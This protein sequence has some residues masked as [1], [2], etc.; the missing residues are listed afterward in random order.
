MRERKDREVCVLLPNKQRL[1]FAVGVKARGREVLNR[2]LEQLGLRELHLFGLAILRDNEYLFLDLEQKLRKSFGSEWRRRSETGPFI[3]FLRVQYYVESGQLILSSKVRQL[4][5]TE[6]R[7]KVLCSQCRHQEALLFQLAASALQAEFGDL[8]QR[9]EEEEEG[10]GEGEGEGRGKK[11]EKD[12]ARHYF[13]PEDYFP[14]W[15]IKRR[16]PDY[17]LQHCPALHGELSGVSRSQAVLQ[18]IREASALQDGPV[19]FYGMTQD[20]EGKQCL[21]YEFSWADI[22][23]LTFQGRR[24]EIHAVGSLCLPKL[25]YYTPSVFHSK[26]ILRHLSD[27]HRL[28]ISTRDTVSYIRQLEETQ[29]SHFYKEAYIC[30]PADLRERLCRNRGVNSLRSSTS[31]HCVTMVT[32]AAEPP[33]WPEEEEEE[34]GSVAEVEMCVD[35]PEEVLVDDPAEVSWLAELL[36]GVSVD[37]PVVP[38]TFYWA[39]VDEE[40]PT[41][42][43][44]PTGTF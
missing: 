12:K 32:P 43:P 9:E 37:G 23:R 7:Q 3:L 25:V 29:A 36:H 4:Y 5:Y 31:D 20:V 15:L 26:H 2:M 6:L 14:S 17:L 41:L 33:S 27:S 39:G 40:S 24:F 38:P 13:R 42:E 34:E 44:E 18:F 19:T 30:D 16:G 11:R 35:E 21:L 8:E 22:D 10:E 1:D 28:H